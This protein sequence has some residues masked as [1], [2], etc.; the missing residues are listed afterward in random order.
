M[1][2]MDPKLR[3]TFEVGASAFLVGALAYLEPIMNGGTLPA[4]AQWGHILL[5]ATVS[6]A[7]MAY[8]RLFPSPTTAASTTSTTVSVEKDAK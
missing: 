1:M 4:Q 2:T 6:G 8:H 5:M 3:A 7:V